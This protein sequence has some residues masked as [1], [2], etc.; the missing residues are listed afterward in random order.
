MMSY[1]FYW[2]VSAFFGL[3]AGFSASGNNNTV[4]Y[5]G[6]NA[7]NHNPN[8]QSSST[9][10]RLSTYC[11]DEVDIVVL[12]F[13]TTFPNADS[14]PAGFAINFAN[15][16]GTKFSDGLLDCTQI[17]E[18]IKTCQEKGIKVLLSLG[19]DSSVSTYGFSKESDGSSFAS[20]LWDYFGEGT[21]QERPFG[22][23]TVD[24]F[25]LDIENK[26]QIGYVS[27]VDKLRELFQ[28]ASKDYF[29]SAAPQCVYP[30]ESLSDV[31]EKSKVDFAFIQFYN[32]PSCNANSEGFNLAKWEEFADSTAYNG[33]IKL[34][35]GVPGADYAAGS[36]YADPSELK[37]I[38]SA[39]QSNAHFGGVMIWDASVAVNNI[40]DDQSY[41]SLVNGYLKQSTNSLS[42]RALSEIDDPII[43]TTSSTAS[44]Q[45]TRTVVQTFY[46]VIVET[47]YEIFTTGIAS[48]QRDSKIKA[49]SPK[50]PSSTP[51]I[52]SKVEMRKREES[53]SIATV[54]NLIAAILVFVSVS[55]LV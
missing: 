45:V 2:L 37:T 31:L 47:E 8:F 42:Q 34:F 23:A 53:G 21:A 17:G 19:G 5:W 14:G 13:L 41:L 24:G 12:A 48:Y 39:H 10:E 54:P 3:A 18:D 9:Q 36:G 11:T 52:V 49:N 44:N 30:D 33:D 46:E 43:D 28:G 51:L 26:D 38:I 7:Y 15:Q 1:H 55:L 40:I 4:V 32:N 50:G 27:M 6:N 20:V 25:D 16:C 29:I 35:V 22:S